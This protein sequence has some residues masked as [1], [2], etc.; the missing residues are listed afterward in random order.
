MSGGLNAGQKCYPFPV[1]PVLGN[2]N[3]VLP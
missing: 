2:I 1:L 3:G